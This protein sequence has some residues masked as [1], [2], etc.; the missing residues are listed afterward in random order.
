MG[1]EKVEVAEASHGGGDKNFA[2]N[3]ED[4]DRKDGAPGV[5]MGGG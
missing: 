5:E 1:S 4:R 3:G 2:G